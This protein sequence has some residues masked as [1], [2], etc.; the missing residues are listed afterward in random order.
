MQ[1]ESPP[2][3]EEEKEVIRTR[4]ARGEGIT[5]VMTLLPGRTPE[6]VKIKACELGLTFCGDGLQVR[7]R[8]W[9]QEKPACCRRTSTWD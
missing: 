4:Y 7:Q 9:Q 5:R 1:R 6:A 8:M 3:T 2:C